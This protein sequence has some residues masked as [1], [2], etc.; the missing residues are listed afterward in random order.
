ML[1]FFIFGV[2]GCGLSEE[3]VRETVKISM[4]E[5]LDSDPDFKDQ[6]MII[7]D[8]QVIKKGDNA[9]RGIATIVHQGSSHDI[10][11]EIFVDGQNVMW[12]APPGSF[13]FLAQKDLQNMFQ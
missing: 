2:A 8:V 12:E 13:L 4:Q 3:D 7:Q 6:K 1:L 10:M 9:Y 11:V 5:T